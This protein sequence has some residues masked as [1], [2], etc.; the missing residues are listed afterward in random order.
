MTDKIILHTPL[1]IALFHG[2]W[3]NINRVGV[4]QY[5]HFLSDVCEASKA[6][7]PYA[8]W[9]LLQSF[10]EMNKIKF[11]LKDLENRC[12]AKLK[13]VRGV[14]L[15]LISNPI[16][17]PLIFRTP[18]S[19]MAAYL[20]ADLDYVIRQLMTLRK[21]GISLDEGITFDQ[22]ATQFRSCIHSAM[23]WKKTGITRKDI[24]EKTDHYLKLENDLKEFDRLP[25]EVLNKEI[26]FEFLP[27]FQVGR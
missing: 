9:F 8:D 13:T 6:D 12:H 23:K 10:N 25:D 17:I 15:S 18:F 5:A 3:K 1:A 20:L 19:F 21:K 22:L 26:R 27:N 11:F 4:R 24:K 7:D 2:S 16:T 14:E